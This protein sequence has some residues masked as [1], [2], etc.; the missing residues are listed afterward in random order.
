MQAHTDNIHETKTNNPLARLTP[1]DTQTVRRVAG[2]HDG[3]SWTTDDFDNVLP[4]D[5]GDNEAD[6]AWWG[7]C[8]DIAGK[9]KPLLDL[10]TC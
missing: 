4:E 3:K 6:E 7:A 2:L 10:E 9:N 1:L 8:P 5:F